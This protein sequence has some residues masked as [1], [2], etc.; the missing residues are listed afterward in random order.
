MKSII[1]PSL[2][3]HGVSLT[4]EQLSYDSSKKR[5]EFL[6]L[7]CG[8]CSV[9]ASISKGKNEDGESCSDDDS[10]D[11]ENQTVSVTRFVNSIYTM[12]SLKNSIPKI[13]LSL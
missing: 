6:V 3:E 7:T 2:L 8:Q 10:E 12:S 1:L 9:N 11:E 5:K 4:G 13:W